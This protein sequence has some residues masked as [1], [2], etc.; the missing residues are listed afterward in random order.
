MS[1]RLN[2]Q[3]TESQHAIVIGAGFA[4]I[5]TALRLRALGYQVSPLE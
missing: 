5:A 4:G 3:A 1:N 2:S